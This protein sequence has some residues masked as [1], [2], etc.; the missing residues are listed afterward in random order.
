MANKKIET[1]LLPTL[2][3]Y[4]PVELIGR[5]DI[6]ISVEFRKVSDTEINCNVWIG[7]DGLNTMHFLRTGNLAYYPDDGEQINTIINAILGDDKMISQIT[8]FVNNYEN[9]QIRT[10]CR[11]KHG[12]PIPIQ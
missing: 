11:R 3:F 12:K 1:L 6:R 8:G 9:H 10:N 4:I 7:V 5:P 2:Q